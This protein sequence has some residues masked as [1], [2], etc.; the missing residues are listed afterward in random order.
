[1]RR[2]ITG[3]AAFTILLAGGAALQ[4]TVAQDAASTTKRYLP[5]YTGTG[6]LLLPNNFEKWVFVGS[7]LTPNVLNDGK[8][9]F[10]EFHNVYMEPG[11]YS[12]SG[13]RSVA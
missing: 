3:V 2:L 10:P 8:A 1:M 4:R 13:R 7:P 11:S 12:V 5:E 9:N 6:D